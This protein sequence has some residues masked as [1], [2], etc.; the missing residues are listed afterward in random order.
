MNDQ[1]DHQLSSERCMMDNFAW[2]SPVHAGTL[3]FVDMQMNPDQA[4]KALGIPMHSSC[5]LDILTELQN[6]NQYTTKYQF[7]SLDNLD[8]YGL[9]A[10]ICVNAYLILHRFCAPRILSLIFV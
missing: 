3:L 1:I 2:D 10:K 8:S 9:I 6:Y 5:I 7:I 4:S